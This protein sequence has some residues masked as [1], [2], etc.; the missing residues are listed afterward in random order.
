MGVLVSKDRVKVGLAIELININKM[1]IQ[2]YTCTLTNIYAH[3][4]P[5]YQPAAL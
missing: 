2:V 3:A 1:Y 4:L 5:Y